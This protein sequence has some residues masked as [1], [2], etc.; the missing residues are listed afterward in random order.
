MMHLD[1]S[2]LAAFYLTPLGRI[3]RQIISS[4]VRAL[5]PT[6][7][8]ERVV[9]L[10]HATPYLRPFLGEAERVVALMPASE[11]VL[12]WPPEGPN[13]TSLTYEDALPLPDNSVDKVLII[14]L[15]ETAKDPHEVLREV[16]RVLVPTGRAL[17]IVPYRSGAWARADQTPMGLGRP[18]SRF[19]L[20]QLLEGA[21]LEPVEMRRCLYVPPT[22]RRFVLGSASAWER[23]GRRVVP[24]FAGVVAIEA[25]KTVM[26]GI[27]ARPR[28]LKDLVPALAPKPAV[29]WGRA[30]MKGAAPVG[31]TVSGAA[32][33]P[34]AR[35][36]G[37]R[38]TTAR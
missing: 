15:L 2:E 20:G 21:W 10:G 13:L 27:P 4:E 12:H 36:T 24:R 14:H 9:G 29:R 3:A 32:G 28:K 22:S 25:Q 31:D 35:R 6:T 16:W 18:F 23:L 26:R 19:Q 7:T 17:A 8:A 5:W 34:P 30:A 37:S 33:T 1:V 38:T 11:G